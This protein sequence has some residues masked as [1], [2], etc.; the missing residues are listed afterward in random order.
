M[1]SFFIAGIGMV[2]AAAVAS[3]RP[4]RPKA[5]EPG[6]YFL[7]AV[8]PMDGETL[9]D[10]DSHNSLDSK[11]TA[12]E[13]EL[14]S[15]WAE[16]CQRRSA[17]FAELLQAAKSEAATLLDRGDSIANRR[18]TM[19]IKLKEL[20]QR[21]VA[22][23]RQDTADAEAGVEKLRGEADERLRKQGINEDT[24]PASS[25]PWAAPDTVQFQWKQRL[26]RE[27]EVERAIGGLNRAKSAFELLNSRL[28]IP[29]ESYRGTVQLLPIGEAAFITMA[30]RK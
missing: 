28:A 25:N 23:Y 8:P 15:D 6:K 10:V 4:T 22:F 27:P 20:M 18:E 21:S 11:L 29:P 7:P 9:A 13:A 5:G 2:A 1:A 12:D 17:E 14:E 26:D 30:M 24:C 3:V 16:F 19:G